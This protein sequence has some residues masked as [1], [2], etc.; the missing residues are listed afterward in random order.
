MGW[1]IASRL[2]RYHDVTVLCSPGVP[3]M[4]DFRG[5]IEEYSATHGPVP[6][7]TFEYV[8]PPLLSYLVQRET[9][10]LRR[11]LYYAGYRSWQ[12]AAAA[13]ARLLHARAPFALVH[14]LN[15]TTFREPGY[16][17]TLPDVPFVWG[18]IGGAADFPDSFLALM[19]PRERLFYRVRNTVNAIQRRRLRRCRTA[20]L[21]A[22]HIWA[23]GDANHDL[24]TRIWGVDAE[25]M[26]EV[27]GEPHHLCRV[28]SYYGDRPLRLVWSGQHLGRKALPL[29]L[30]AMALVRDT[31]AM[32]LTVLGHGPES[33]SWKALADRLD[34]T[35]LVRWAGQV[36]R[37]R[38]VAA[39]AEAD[40]FVSTSVLEETSLVVLEA[41][42]LG[43]P[44]VCHD[45]CGMREAVTD[46][47]GIKVPLRT[48]DVSVRGFAAAIRV[49]A[50]GGEPFTERSR[51]ALV[52]SRELDWDAKAQ[53]MASRYTR[54][55]AAV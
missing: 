26:L 52:R 33:R 14:Q 22:R 24:A 15:I 8:E 12:R 6:G 47:C 43:L 16:L 37:D 50:A 4:Q 40:V 46:A 3:G 19:S 35:P 29:L 23:V 45:A 30:Q 13:R 21:R 39:M 55:I 32:E 1:N 31:V 10:L 18:P 2:A 25:R 44:V 17:W 51:G 41:L 53:T 38:A 54:V 49:L 28:R 34:L 11:T 27:G 5:E 20:A 9:P 48:P 7:L 42:S 36:P